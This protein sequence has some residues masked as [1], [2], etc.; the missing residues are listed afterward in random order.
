MPQRFLWIMLVGLAVALGSLVLSHNGDG[1]NGFNLTGND[2]ASL[3]AEVTILMVL[4]FTVM[5]LFRDRFAQALQAALFWV[6]AMVTLGAV[7]TY[8]T[9]LQQVGSRMLA[10]LIPGRPVQI[11]RTVQVARG[12]G[13]DFQVST[14]INGARVAM[15]LDTGASSVVLTHEAA[16]AAGLPLE[17]LTYTV[18]IDTANGHSRAAAVTLDRLA[19]GGIV[20]RAVPA[21]IAQ[22]GHLKESLLGMTFLNRLES[23]EMRGDRLLMRA[24]P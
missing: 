18:E 5:M 13:G 24:K 1:I 20:E 23:Y 10:E 14:Q 3:V 7:Y 17:I 19:V 6:A 16:K 22:S 11:G 15:V 4:C 8:R 2:Y 21:L 9:E 12:H